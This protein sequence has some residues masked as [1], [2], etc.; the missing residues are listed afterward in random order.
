MPAKK[1][2]SAKPSEPKSPASSH[3]DYGHLVTAIHSA[4]EHAVHR[5]AV[6]VNQWL[7][8]RNWMVGAYLVEYEQNGSDRAK[9]GEKLLERLSLDLA[10]KGVKGLNI[11]ILDRCRLF[12]RTYPELVGAI[13]ATLSPEFLLGLLDRTIPSSALTE[14]SPEKG[15]SSIPATVSPELAC[16][17]G[18]TSIRGLVTREFPTPLSPQV[19]LRLSWSKLQE[20]IRIDD[21][22]RRAFYENECLKS[23][24]SVRQLQRQIESLLYERTGL[25]SDKKTVIE[26]ARKQEPQ[27][28]IE[29]LIRDPYILEFAGLADRPT[30]SENDLK[31]LVFARSPAFKRSSLSPTRAA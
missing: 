28:S 23:Q 29:D 6:A 26:R 30:Y 14:S 16:V 18:S 8:I 1:K 19:L 20:L 15:L 17:E 25:S 22:W 3:L 10:K 11:R 27:E 2:A 24:W 13:P 4:S 5:A 21:P 7:V 9:Y 12:Y 31:T